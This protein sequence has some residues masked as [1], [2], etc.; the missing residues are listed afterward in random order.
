[1]L[2]RVGLVIREGVVVGILR[3]D[4]R[5]LARAAVRRRVVTDIVLFGGLC[6]FA[7]GGGGDDDGF[8]K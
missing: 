1:V 3:D 8:C 2:V 5:F 4:F 7:G 6:D